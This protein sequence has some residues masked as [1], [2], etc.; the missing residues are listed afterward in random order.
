MAAE[1]VTLSEP[2]T[3]SLPPHRGST[4]GIQ[5][6]ESSTIHGSKLKYTLFPSPASH[7]LLYSSAEARI[8]SRRIE[9]FLAQHADERLGSDWQLRHMTTS[10]KWDV[11]NLKKWQAVAPCSEPIAGV[12]RAMKTMREIDDVHSPT[13]FVKQYSWKVV[14]DGVALVVDISLDA[15]VYD[16]KGLEDGGVEYHKFP[17]VSKQPPGA[18]EVEQFISLID[19]LRESPKI[20]TS[21]HPTIGVHCHYGFNRY[22]LA[23][24]FHYSYMLINNRTGFLIVCYLVERLQWKLQ[25]AIEEFAQKRPPGIKHQHFVDEL[26]VR[27][28]VKQERRMTIV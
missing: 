1:R 2:D 26:Y 24:R 19:G 9:T 21:G 28:A 25:D 6:E 5:Q 15:P 10:G 17:T 22:G 12:F 4:T 16:K 23:V 3:A 14:P 7:G 13:V 18:D 8:L 20:Q 27:Y 11:K